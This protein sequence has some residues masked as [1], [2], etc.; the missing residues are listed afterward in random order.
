MSLRLRAIGEAR[1]GAAWAG[2]F[3]MPLVFAALLFT[4]LLFTTLPGC[5]LKGPPRPLGQILPVPQD[6]RVRQFDEAVLISWRAVAREQAD[7]RGGLRAHRLW[8]EELPAGCPSCLPLA[9]RELLLGADDPGLPAEGGQVLHS[10]RPERRE[11]GWRVRVSH[12]FG[13]GESRAAV[14]AAMPG[15]GRI[16]RPELRWE[17][18]QPPGSDPQDPAP[19]IRLSWAPELDRE[20]VIVEQGAPP[21]ERSLNFRTNLYRRRGDAEWPS[22][23]LNATPIE[24]EHW[25]EVLPRTALDA[26]EESFEYAIRWVDQIG[27]EG[28]RSDPVRISHPA[29]SPR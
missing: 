18:D 21:Q 7:R 12:R 11:S 27:G 9:T 8:I 24:E 20:V 10:F 2:A 4:A 23:P 15:M 5:G 6:L 13:D 29:R 22:I 19:A 25:R 26:G 3:L 28:A 16:P 17:W 1:L 14:S